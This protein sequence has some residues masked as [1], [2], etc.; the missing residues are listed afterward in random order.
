MAYIAPNPKEWNG[1]ISDSS[2]YIYQRIQFNELSELETVNLVTFGILGYGVDEGVRRNQGRI[3]AA[4]GP[5]AFR[6]CF[7][8]LADHFPKEK[9]LIDVGTLECDNKNLEQVQNELSSAVSLLLEKGINPI[10]IGGGH[11]IAYGHYKGIQKAYPNKRIGIINFDAH[12]DLRSFDQG[13]HSGSPFNQIAAEV[14]DFN[15]LC[16]GFR[17]NTNSPSLLQQAKALNVQLIERERCHLNFIA[18]VLDEINSFIENLDLVYLSIDLD[19]FA[20]AYAPGVSAASPFG[21]DIDF[22]QACLKHLLKSDKIISVDVAELN[23]EFDIDSRTSKL[24]AG[25]IYQIIEQWT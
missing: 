25:L 16:V 7:S 22:V 4:K 13:A 24:A 12:L 17:K 11:D 6:K 9:Q 10:V 20:D 3:G 14:D 15:Y 21:F 8:V 23:P 19:G 1:R 18:Q 2:Q 5:L